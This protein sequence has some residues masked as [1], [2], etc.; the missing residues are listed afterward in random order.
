[1]LL[2]KD[3]VAGERRF[4]KVLERHGEDGMIYFIHGE[5]YDRWAKMNLR[6]IE[7]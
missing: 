3:R 1:M 6:C 2:L 5:G 4:E 7:W